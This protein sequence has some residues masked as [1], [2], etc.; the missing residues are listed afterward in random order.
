MPDTK[1]NYQTG[2]LSY[3]EANA[4]RLGNNYYIVDTQSTNHLPLNFSYVR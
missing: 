1:V 4:D 3:K 2:L